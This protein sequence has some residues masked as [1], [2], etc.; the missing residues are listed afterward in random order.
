MTYEPRWGSWFGVI[1]QRRAPRVRI[2]AVAAGLHALVEL[3]SDA[4]EDAVV[5]RA[6]RHGLAVESLGDYG[7]RDPRHPALVVGYGTPPA[8]LFAGAV[9]RL[10]AVLG[11]PAGGG[12]P[13]SRP[14]ARRDQSSAKRAAMSRP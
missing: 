14:R 5:A 10:G 8:H 6:A 4:F 13:R 1:L 12:R 11:A 3:E 2:A 9:S 7:P